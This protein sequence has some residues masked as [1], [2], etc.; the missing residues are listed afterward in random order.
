MNPEQEMQEQMPAEEMPAE[1]MPADAQMDAQQEQIM[2]IAQTA[3]MPEKPYS[4]KAI[5]KMADAMNEFVGSVTPEM[6]AAEYNPPEG[7]S[8]LDGPLPPEVYVPFAVIMGFISQLGDAK[9]EKFIIQPESLVSDTALAKAAAN[10]KRMQKDKKLLE[11]LQ[12]P[13]EM[14]EEEDTGMSDAEME[15]GRGMPGDTDA[16][17]EEIMQM[18]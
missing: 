15:A 4:Y 11:A 8:K 9:F 13:A 14:E 1:E 12:G 7:E 10:F 5:D 16:E 17:D 3:P 18:M 6:Q 2:Q